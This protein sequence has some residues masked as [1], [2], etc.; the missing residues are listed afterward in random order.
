[1]VYDLERGC[2]DYQMPKT[3]P[4]ANPVFFRTYSNQEIS[5]VSRS[6][7]NPEHKQRQEA[8][9]EALMQPVN[10]KVQ[11]LLRLSRTLSNTDPRTENIT[12]PLAH[13]QGGIILESL[14]REGPSF[15]AD[16]VNRTISLNRE[17]A[18]NLVR[19]VPKEWRVYALLVFLFHDV[20][21]SPQGLK[22]HEDVRRLKITHESFGQERMGELDLRNDFLAVHTISLYGTLKE[23]KAY[24]HRNYI[25][26]FYLIWNE[27]CGSMLDAFP[28]AQRK[29]KQ[30]RVFGFLLMSN[31]INDAH[32]EKR[33]LEFEGEMWPVWDESLSHLSILS[34]GHILHPGSPVDS[35]LM[36]QIIG[37]ISANQYREAAF[38]IKQVW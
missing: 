1:M 11:D 8:A 27:V 2:Q 12:V 13:Y 28:P 14:G 29:D 33:P 23:C 20:A 9:V 35:Q 37:L 7:A 22:H 31:L 5:S 26:R 3:A 36:A 24:N 34:N 30:Q 38:G 18:I 25:A 16:D 32:L 4:A 15:R 19:M 21:H 10:A 17:T 6:T